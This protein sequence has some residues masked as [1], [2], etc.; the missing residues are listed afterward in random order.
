MRA[1]AQDGRSQARN[2]E[3]AVERLVA[4]LREGLKVRKGRRPTRPSK[5]AKE[6][7]LKEKRQRSEHKRGRKP[8]R[9]DD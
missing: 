6:R 2:R 7:R 8:P 4:K 3:L 1:V 5:G 9:D